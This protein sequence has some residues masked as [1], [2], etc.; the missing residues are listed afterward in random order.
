MLIAIEGIDGVGKTTI[1]KFLKEELEKR[2]YEV[3]LL[4]EPTNSEWGRKIKASLNKRLSAEEELELFILDRKY[5]VEHNI[6]PA[7]KQ[8]KIVIMDRYYYSNIAYQ[9]A[10]GLDAERIKRI[11]EEIAPRPDIVILLDAPPEI[12]LER[13]MERGEIPNSF[14][15]PEYLKKVREIFKSLKDNVVIVDASKSIDEVKKDV[16]R[17]VLERI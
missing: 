4:K 7:L 1:A 10:R 8:G 6:L 14:E 17:I 5:N 9:A 3:V 16:L 2:G 12:C 15:D 11:N 13:I